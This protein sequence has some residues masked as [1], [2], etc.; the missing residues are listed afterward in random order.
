MSRIVTIH[1]FD[2]GREDF[3]KHINEW[4]ITKKMF[5]G[6]KVELTNVHNKKIK[7]SSISSWK[8]RTIEDLDLIKLN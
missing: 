3:K 4:I 7:I 6:S 1:T 8:T 5:N 2:D